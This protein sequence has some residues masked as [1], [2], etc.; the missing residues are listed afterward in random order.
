MSGANDITEV[1]RLLHEQ[2][3]LLRLEYERAAAPIIERLVQIRAM[4]TMT[5]PIYIHK[6]MLQ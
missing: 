5:E 2:L 4:R 1:E 3:T 6:D